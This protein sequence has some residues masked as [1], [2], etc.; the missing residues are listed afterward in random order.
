MSGEKKQFALFSK[1]TMLPDKSIAATVFIK[2]EKISAI[3]E[4]KITGTTSQLMDV[5]DAV[6]MPGIIDPHVHINEPGRTDWEGFATATQAAAA[7]GITTLVDMPLNSTPVTINQKSYLKK[8]AAAQDKCSVNVFFWGG[9]VPENAGSISEILNTDVLGIKAFLTHSGIDDFP[10]VTE[11]ELNKIMPAI[12]HSG[13]QLLVHCELDAP[14]AGQNLLKQ[15]PTSYRAWLKSRP[16]EWENKAINLMIRLCEKYNCPVHIVHLS[17][18]E[19][20]PAIQSAKEKGLPLTVETCPHYLYFNAEN[21]PDANTLFKC[22]PP[23]REE[24][25]NQKLFEAL[26]NGLIDFVA[27]DH[28]PATPGLKEIDTGNFLK[29]WG[30][31]ASLQFSLSVIWTLARKN[32]LP[33]ERL[34]TWLCENPA[35]LI[36]KADLKGKIKVGFDADLVVWNPEEKFTITKESIQFRHKIS[37]YIGE[38]VY[39]KI[40]KTFV[41]GNQVW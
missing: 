16:K 28:S 27:T 3:E 39:G 40:L 7:G 33:L 32:R 41:A 31:I 18:A 23:I 22:A 1:R 21:I 36:K 37:P 17:S 13:K 34:K 4:G 9:A 5:G 30:G 38:E 19:A 15:D 2:G 6:L 24:E 14:N 20:L 25:N 26:Q 35:K 29:A 8:V 10:N 12:A 11:N